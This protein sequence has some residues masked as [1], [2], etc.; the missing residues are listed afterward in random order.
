MTIDLKDTT[1][2]I[3]L[4]I[5]SKDRAENAKITL[6]YLCHHLDTNIIVLEYDR[7][8][9]KLKNILNDINSN[10]I[11]HR[12]IENTSGN[13][14]FHRTRFLNEMLSTVTTPV[15]VNYDIDI[16]LEP[17]AYRRCSD[18]I[19][20]GHDLIYPYFWGNSQ[21][22]IYNSGREKIKNTLSLDS[23]TNTDKNLT[24]SEYGHCQWFKTKS[25][26][27]GGMENE[28][29]LSYGPEDKER[30][31]RFKKMGY[32]VVW[33]N[34]FV[35]HIEHSRTENSSGHNP[36]MTHN[37]NL[38]NQLSKLNKEQLIYY[39]NNVDYIKKYKVK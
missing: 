35:Y 29:F 23:L 15:V 6:S 18:F 11:D 21:Y 22:Q 26:I 39:Y 31:E 27:E 38:F 20:G 10:N 25:Y 8:G 17:Y 9:S 4:C 12:F 13:N 19:I 16:V 28:N 5:E 1:F 3:P 36:M 14:I 34:F 2:I 37:N 7:G 32:T 24:R 30:G 33:S